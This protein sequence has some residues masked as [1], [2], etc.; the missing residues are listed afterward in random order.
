MSDAIC[1]MSDARCRMP[2]VGC[3]IQNTIVC[4]VR[5]FSF[6]FDASESRHTGTPAYRHTGTPAH[7]HTGTPAYRHTG[8]PAY[9][10]TGTPA[11]RHTGTLAY[12]YLITNPTY[13]L[14]EL[15]L[16]RLTLGCTSWTHLR[17]SVA[18]CSLLKPRGS[19]S[20]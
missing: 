1:Q 3:Q 20:L 8:T 15:F 13:P 10:H 9:R 12:H 18:K 16:E 11:Y 14:L 4:S 6:H 5:L 19:W 17:N 7:R 2:D